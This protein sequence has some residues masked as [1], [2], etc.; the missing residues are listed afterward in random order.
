MDQGE[1][2]AMALRHFG[3]RNE[4]EEAETGNLLMAKSGQVKIKK[5]RVETNNPGNME[6]FRTKIMLMTNHFIFARFRYPHTR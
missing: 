5:A 4:D 6:E 1:F 2:R 3:S